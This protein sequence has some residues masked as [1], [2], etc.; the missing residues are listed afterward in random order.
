MRKT[1]WKICRIA[2]IAI[3]V[4]TYVC[5]FLRSGMEMNLE[6]DENY[7]L[8]MES[9]YMD[10][11]NFDFSHFDVG[12]FLLL[13]IYVFVITLP[14]ITVLRN[15]RMVDSYKSGWGAWIMIVLSLLFF[16]RYAHNCLNI[17]LGGY[18][19]S[20]NEESVFILWFFPTLIYLFASLTWSGISFFS[21]T[22]YIKKTIKSNNHET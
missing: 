4:A 11:S 14:W 22:L 6:P 10:V 3:L 9:G 21:M 12:V 7:T 17:V 15:K 8:N 16:F 18:Y 1:V 2:V 20:G 19:T 13:A 5:T